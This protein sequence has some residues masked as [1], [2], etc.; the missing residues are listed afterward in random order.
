MPGEDAFLFLTKIPHLFIDKCLGLEDKIITDAMTG[1]ITNI[2]DEKHPASPF[3]Q[4]PFG[5]K[6]ILWPTKQHTITYSKMIYCTEMF[7]TYSEAA[8]SVFRF[9]GNDPYKAALMAALFLNSVHDYKQ[10]RLTIASDIWMASA[11][12]N[13][14][15]ARALLYPAVDDDFPENTSF[16]YKSP[17]QFDKD[18]YW[19]VYGMFGNKLGGICSEVRY[20]LRTVATHMH[21]YDTHGAPDNASN[22]WTK[23][24]DLGHTIGKHDVPEAL[25]MWFQAYYDGTPKSLEEPMAV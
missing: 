2:L 9:A 8:A 14:K 19:Q 21:H 18:R 12:Q 25:K 10:N 20:V 5:Y 16:I 7:G 3:W 11:F 15:L 1:C 13:C 23:L 22:Y 4:G 6:G 17:I 24:P